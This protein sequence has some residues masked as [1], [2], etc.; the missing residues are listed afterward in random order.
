[1]RPDFQG[2]LKSTTCKIMAGEDYFSDS[3][4]DVT[5]DKEASQHL[6]GKWLIEVSEMHAMSRAENAH[7]K[8]FITREVERYR[9]SYGRKEV[10]EERQCVFVGTTNKSTYL[11]DETGA[12]RF[13]PVVTGRIEVDALR[14]VRDQLYAEAV[15]AFREGEPWW[16]DAKL[17]REVIAPEQDARYDAD[18]WEEPIA[19]YLRNGPRPTVGQIAREALHIELPRISRG[20]QLRISAIMERLG[21]YRLPK[22]RRGDRRWAPR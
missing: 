1:L 4:P 10:V 19:D 22:D 17:E 7:L 6:R 8:A 15:C 13:W 11:R 16:P 9:P 12:R 14:R 20:D 2:N 18:A 5:A 21:W 3:L